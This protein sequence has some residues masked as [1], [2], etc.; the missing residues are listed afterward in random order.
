V[1]RTRVIAGILVAVAV[2]VAV[3]FLVARDG[4][5]DDDGD[6]EFAHI[7]ALP[8][9]FCAEVE[10]GGAGEPNAL[11]VS[12][13]PMQG[14]SA[15]RSAQMVEAIRQE[16][17]NQNWQAGE[18]RIAYQVCDDSIAETGEWDARRCRDNAANYANNSDVIGVIGTYN[19]GCAAEMIR[20][21]NEAPDG[22]VAMV[23]PG[24]TLIC[25]TELASGCERGQPNSLYPSG[26]RNYARVVPNDAFQGAGLASFARDQGVRRPYVLFAADDPTSEGQGT[27]FQEAAQALALQVV[28][29]DS[30]DPEAADYTELMQKVKDAGAD[31]VVLAGLLEQNGPQIIRDKVKV[32]GPNNGRVKLLAP[33]GF[34]QQATIDDTGP[35]SAGMFVSVPG[36][37]PDSLTG[38]G[39]AF[40]AQLEAQIGGAPVELY[41]P[42]A[43]QAAEVLLSAIAPSAKRA[44]II[45]ALLQAKVDQGIVGNFEITPTG[46][47]SVGPISVSVAR[48][49]FELAKEIS[50]PANLVTAARGGFPASIPAP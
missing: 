47:P 33:D 34:A 43:G 26:T 35:T 8:A 5:D 11:I 38:P 9:S 18:T 32:L 27:T 20:I 3:I 25:L 24:N 50:P 36:R 2:V 23:S 41:A 48:D 44:D 30:W 14:D 29:F 19:S 40:V 17:E 21:L 6:E 7:E 37:T 31:T 15:E 1:P 13:L 42:Y 45:T 49:T 4:D 22:G 16:L 28:G 10:F 12:D 39:K 46:D